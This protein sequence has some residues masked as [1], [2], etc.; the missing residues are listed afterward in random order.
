MMSGHSIQCWSCGAQMT[1]GERSSADG[2]CPECDAEIDL[3]EYYPALAAR[4]AE[5]EAALAE[6]KYR[7]E[8]GR[9][10]NGMGWTLTGLSPVGQQ[11]ALDA[12]NQALNQE[13]PSDN[14]R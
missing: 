6:A 7:V 1:L 4:C 5:L 3:A 9:V 2:Y 12:I 11:K 13:D 14:R 10:W 8:Q